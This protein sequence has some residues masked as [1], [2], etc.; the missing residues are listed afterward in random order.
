M[1]KVFNVIEG[2]YCVIS[3]KSK[4]TKD[5]IFNAIDNLNSIPPLKDVPILLPLGNPDYIL[6]EI[7]HRI[8]FAFDGPKL[9]T[10][11]SHLLD[12]QQEKIIQPQYMPHI[13]IVNNRYHRSKVGPGATKIP[14]NNSKNLEQ[15]NFM[16]KPDS[17]E[18]LALCTC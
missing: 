13:I 15:C 2:C 17:S 4:I 8:I 9:E 3:V 1:E 18:E 6:Q 16:T 7:P 14:G 11:K 12:C 5:E 10:T